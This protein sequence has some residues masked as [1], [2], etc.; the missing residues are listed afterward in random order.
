MNRLLGKF[1]LAIT[2]GATV[3]F[4]YFYYALYFK[5]R[6]CFNDEGRCFDG[7]TGTVYLEQSGMVWLSLA[8]FSSCIL[9]FQVWR[10][11]R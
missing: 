5:W 9:L 7:E 8:V 4:W 11:A 10:M 1:V 2:L 6:D 3:L